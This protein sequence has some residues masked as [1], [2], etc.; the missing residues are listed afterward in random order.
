MKL[1]SIRL[2]ILVNIIGITFLLAISDEADTIKKQTSFTKHI[3]TQDFISEGV[4][5]GD[6]NKDGKPDILAGAFW[7][8]APD[9]IRHEIDTAQIFP[10][11]EGRLGNV[12]KSYSN[13]MLNFTM[14]VNGDGWVDFI[15]IGFPGRAAYWYENP[16]GNAGYWKKYLIYPT[17]GNES[18]RFVDVDGDGRE[19]MLCGDTESKQMIWLKPPDQKG[20]TEWTKYT[21]SEKDVFGADRFH[22]GLGYEDINGDERKDVIT[23]NGWWEGPTDVKQPNW[24]YHPDTLGMGEKCAQILALDVDGD[25]DQD[26]FSSS[27]HSR[28]IWWHE[29]LTGDQSKI[30][31][32][33]HL[34]I[35]EISQTHALILTDLNAD[36]RLD[37]ITGKRYLAARGLNEGAHEPAKL[38]WIEFEQGPNPQ[39]KIHQID[40]DSGVGLHIVAQDVTQDGFMDIVT[41]NKKGVFLFEQKQD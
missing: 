25:G 1:I 41:A 34:I 27:A 26:L 22:H 18:P 9:W 8:E 33:T 21:I 37:L 15:R 29:Q 10:V 36:G 24:Q 40:D 30:S 39:W 17:I 6:V 38:I 2:I 12:E 7:F 19:D 16:K 28:G 32:K 14:D 20:K 4:A 31:W 35:D 13:S 23:T 3:L 5:V 11:K